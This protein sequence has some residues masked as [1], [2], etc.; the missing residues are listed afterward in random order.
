M[1]RLLAICM[2]CLCVAACERQPGQALL[3]E[4]VE[5]ALQTT[6]GEEAFTIVDFARRGSAVDSTAAESE[7]RR[8]VYYDI[9]LET[10]N[11]IV[12]GDWDDPGAASLVTLLGAGP[13]SIQGVKAGGNAAGDRIVAHASAIYRQEGDRWTF[14][15]PAGFH[16]AGR[17]RTETGM[18]L[19]SAQTA[20]ERLAEITRSVEEGGSAAAR[21]IVD[22]EL[23]RSLA[24]VA[25]RLSRMDQGYPLAAGMAR[26]EYAAFSGALAALARE[27][28]IRI[29]PL[30][31]GGSEENIELLRE[32]SAVLALAQADTAHAAYAGTGQFAGR[33]QFTSLRALGSLYPEYVHI[34]VR[35]AA[36]LRTAADLKGTRIG[37]GPEGSAVRSTLMRVLA[38]HGLQPDRDYQPVSLRGGEALAALRRNEI[39]AAAHVIG[40]PATPLRDA[41]GS[42]KDGLN[43]LPLDEAAVERLAAADNGTIRAVIAAGVYPEQREA[44]LTVAV[45]ALLLGSESLP[46]AEVMQLTR[47][48]YQGGHDLMAYGSAQGSQVAAR[49]A[50]RGL[51]VPLHKGADHALS[52]LGTRAEG[53]P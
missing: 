13:R 37:L 31:T 51:T 8:V 34:V 3:R 49:T 23:Q 41:L 20:L 36:G 11:D 21:S 32:G 39:D 30:A 2:L 1:L 27:H 5:S 14:V 33:G 44:V 29:L 4:D 40:L 45:P 17:P 25:G 16:D 50:R 42:G 9:E 28:Q 7:T 15:M 47:M 19:S 52:E 46:E 12:L 26:G 10:M 22:V 43:L 38:E 48:V 18:P 6:F 35:G 53:T 24:R